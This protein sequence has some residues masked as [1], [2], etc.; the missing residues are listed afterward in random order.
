[1]PTVL[2]YFMPWTFFLPAAVAWW[3]RDGPDPGHRYVLWWTLTLW[4]LVGL[5]GTYRARYFLP[6]YPGLAVLVGEFFARGGRCGV[7]REV[8][9]GAIAFVILS[10]VVLIAMVLP[11]VG[12]SGEGPVYIPDTLLE[13][14]LVAVLAVMGVAGVLLAARRD[15]LIGLGS[16]I[17]VVLGAILA[18]E[19][20]TSPVRRARYYDVP[21]LGAAATMHLPPDG[22]LFAYPDLSLQYD[23]YVRRRIVEIGADELHRVLAAASRDAV[24][25]TRRRWAAE[26]TRAPAVGWHVVEA[27]TVGGVDIVLVGR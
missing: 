26:Q 1:M 6:V 11:P 27:R 23:V 5:S 2:L 4:V 25:M 19:G 21:A 22:T 18:I 7:R 9:V 13:R 15:T 8:R 14:A 20:Y 24:I 12:L 3:R 10:L 16:V 17:A